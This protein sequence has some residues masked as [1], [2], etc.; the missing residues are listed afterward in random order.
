MGSAPDGC[1]AASHSTTGPHGA[2]AVH[3]IN[4][5]LLPRL[6]RRD[7]MVAKLKAVKEEL[8]RRRHQPI[9]V[10]GARLAQVVSG[11]FNYHAVPTNARAL[12]AF[13]DRVV[14][15]W[16]RSLRRRSQRDFTTWERMG[17]SPATGCPGHAFC[18]LGRVNASPS[19]T[20]GGSRVPELGPLGSVRG[21]SAMSVPTA[22]RLLA[23]QLPSGPKSP[24]VRC[25]AELSGLGNPWIF[26]K[27]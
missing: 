23:C 26:I 27:Y 24:V 12:S 15:L 2:G 3:P 25:R 13:R 5:I 4:P 6:T 19:N 20:R 14:E 17:S 18:I 10:Q 22:I 16:R 7:R 9:P 1:C 11:F 8:R 21:R